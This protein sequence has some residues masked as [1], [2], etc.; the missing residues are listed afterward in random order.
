MSS[1]RRVLTAAAG[2]AQSCAFRWRGIYWSVLLGAV[3]EGSRFYPHVQIYRASRVKLGRNVVIN[4]F[5]HIWGGGG[6]EIGDDSLIAAQCTITSQTHAA[7]ALARGQLYRDTWIPGQVRIGSNVWLGSGAIILPG[8]TIG[9]NSIV[10]AGAVVTA[11]IPSGVLAAGVPA[12]VVKEL[13][14]P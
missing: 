14:K 2:L 12:R 8:V 3:G 5:V 1:L 7:D 11:D 13:P 6:V 10:A 4:D 9:D